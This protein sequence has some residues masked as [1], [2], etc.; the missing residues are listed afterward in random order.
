M[1][2]KPKQKKKRWLWQDTIVEAYTKSEARGEFKRLFS[3][4]RLPQGAVVREEE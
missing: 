1:K 3:L 4:K 2:E